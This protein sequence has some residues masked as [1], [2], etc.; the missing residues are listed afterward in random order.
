MASSIVGLPVGFQGTFVSKETEMIP[1]K[2]IQN[3]TRNRRS[4]Q[5]NL[6]EP[7]GGIKGP[8][9]FGLARWIS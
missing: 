9:R 6:R 1:L 8:H 5:H 7:V 2:K 3:A 4:K